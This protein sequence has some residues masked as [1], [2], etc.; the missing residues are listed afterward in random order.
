MARNRTR[1]AKANP[2][3][4][5]FT[6]AQQTFAN[7]LQTRTGLN[8]A[9]IY[10]W[11]A[12]EQGHGTASAPNGTNNWL[13]IGSTDSG[14]YGGN[15]PAWTDPISAA[16]QTA[17]WLAGGSTFGYGH[18]S[19]GIVNVLKTAGQ[20]AATQIAALQGS[21]WASSG[22]PALESDYQSY[23]SGAYSGSNSAGASGSGSQ[24]TPSITRR[25]GGAG[26]SSSTTYASTTPKPDPGVQFAAMQ[27]SVVAP[28][29]VSFGGDLL[30]PFKF[31]LGQSLSNWKDFEG[32]VKGPADAL[33]DG[34]D[35]VEKL[36]QEFFKIVNNWRFYA[37]RFTEFTSGVVLM[38]IGLWLMMSGGGGTQTGP[39]R[40][41]RTVI[42][43]TPIGREARAAGATRAGRREGHAEHYRLKARTEERQRLSTSDA[44]SQQKAG[45][46][47]RG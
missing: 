20:S 28:T 32:E 8:I 4:G 37:M 44:R 42:Q 11:M 21:G 3:A 43:A 35:A 12:A 31:A 26:A 6:T 7:Q 39:A 2:L 17:S 19:S 9:V 13:N 15:N 18:A 38:G 30:A 41:L 34:A 16:N 22:Y 10:A 40:A 27:D 25:P 36:S 24:V 1:P 29:D 47:R 5:G 14:Y 45:Q 33:V 46:A 23:L